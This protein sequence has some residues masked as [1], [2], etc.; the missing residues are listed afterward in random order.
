[1]IVFPHAFQ[2]NFHMDN[3]TFELLLSKIDQ[4][5]QPKRATRFADSISPRQR[6]AMTLEYVAYFPFLSLWI[7]QI[8]EDLSNS[9]GT[10]RADP[11]KD[12]L[13]VCID[14][15]RRVVVL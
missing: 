1:M 8:N 15:Q 11:S 7:K 4:Y 9:I 13:Q 6:L 3:D 12:T 2:E 10:M 5:L 14:F